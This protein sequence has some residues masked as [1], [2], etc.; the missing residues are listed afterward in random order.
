MSLNPGQAGLTGTVGFG[1]SNESMVPVL[2]DHRTCRPCERPCR[3]EVGRAA[4]IE[5]D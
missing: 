1:S 2:R 5:H 4:A 3:A